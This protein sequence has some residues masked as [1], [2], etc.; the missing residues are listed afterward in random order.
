[1][2]K[3]RKLLTEAKESAGTEAKATVGKIDEALKLLE[4]SHQNMHEQ[5]KH[6][7][8]M[9]HWGMRHK[10][11]MSEMKCP[12]CGQMLAPQ[13]VNDVCPITGK[14]FEPYNLPD[15]RMREF[16]GSKVGFCCPNCPPTWDKLSDSEKQKK[17]DEAMKSSS[18]E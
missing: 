9:M 1:M 18:G 4:K 16:K 5:M 7:M 10:G 6:H 3:L 11:K 17:L 12:M 15:D 13:V 2:A 8:R 14:K